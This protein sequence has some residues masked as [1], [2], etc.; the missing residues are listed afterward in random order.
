MSS[1]ATTNTSSTS[2][3][4]ATNAPAHG[5]NAGNTFGE[6]VRDG[7]N[8]A[9]GTG[10]AIRGTFNSAMDSLGDA[11]TGRDGHAKHQVSETHN[12]GIANRG[13]NDVRQG[14]DHLRGRPET[15]AEHQTGGSLPPNN[16]NLQPQ[17]NNPTT[18][19]ADASGETAGAGESKRGFV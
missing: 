5:R 6:K 4:Y 15:T 7:F 3:A 8:V 10:D 1:N 11:I 13:M 19:A 17:Y 18:A 16:V 9:G 14:M 2:P 12:E